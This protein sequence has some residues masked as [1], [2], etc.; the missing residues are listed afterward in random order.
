MGVTR[1]LP[2]GAAPSTILSILALADWYVE[3][4]RRGMDLVM[5]ADDGFLISDS[6]F[7]AE[8]PRGFDFALEKSR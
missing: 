5:Y 6:P 8:P 2:Q 1:G 3:V 7:H 4:K